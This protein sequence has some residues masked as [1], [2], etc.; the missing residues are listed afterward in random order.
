[1]RKRISQCNKI[2]KFMKTHKKGINGL[3]A[4]RVAGSMN[5]PQRIYDLKKRGEKIEDE[6]IFVKG[7]DGEIY[8]VKQYRLVK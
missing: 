2:L 3:Q 5:L 7:E 1:M 8:R 4:Y 6:Y